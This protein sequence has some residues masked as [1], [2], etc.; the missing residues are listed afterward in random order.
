MQLPRRICRMRRPSDWRNPLTRLPGPGVAQAPPG[1]REPRIRRITSRRAWA[2]WTRRSTRSPAAWESADGDIVPLAIELLARTLPL[3]GRDADAALVWQR[4]S[5]I[6]THPL[7]RPCGRGCAARSAETRSRPTATPRAAWW[8]R[9]RGGRR[10]LRHAAVAGQRAFRRSGPDILAARPAAGPG[11]RP[12]PRPAGGPAQRGPVPA[13]T[14]GEPALH[15]S[16]RAR[17]RDAMGAASDVLPAD[18]PDT[19]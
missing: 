11:R 2:T 19:C 9:V 16:F 3:R 17:L 14:P 10:L 8:G 13:S 12:G 1:G 7:R 15:E 4:P 18:W 6:R 5:R